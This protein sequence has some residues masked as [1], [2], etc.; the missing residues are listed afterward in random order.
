M[1][2]QNRSKQSNI[3][4]YKLEKVEQ[5][6]NYEIRINTVKLEYKELFRSFQFRNYLSIPVA[7]F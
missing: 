3:I 5:I 1:V 7:Y 6:L 4:F 2:G